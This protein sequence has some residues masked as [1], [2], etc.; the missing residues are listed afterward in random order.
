MEGRMPRDERPRR[1]RLGVLTVGVA[2]VLLLAVAVVPDDRR[3]APSQYLRFPVVADTYVSAAQPDAV[4]GAS[5]TLVTAP[6]GSKRAY[7]RFVITGVRGRVTA[8]TLRVFVT[9]KLTR[10]FHV[11]ATDGADL[12][13]GAT[14]D[15]SA[16]G[17]GAIVGSS[18]TV[19]GKG[20]SFVSVTPLVEGD[21]SVTLALLASE[22][23]TTFASRESGAES[24]LIVR[25]GRPP[26]AAA[27][28]ARPAGWSAR[29]PVIGAA[30]DIACD[31]TVEGTSEHSSSAG[32][33][34]QQMATSDLL[35]RD[36]VVAV[37]PLGDNQ[38][39]DGTLAKYRAWYAPSWGR[40]KRITRP[41]PGNHEYVRSG[42]SLDAS[43][44]FRYFGAAAGDPAKGY[45]S[46]DIGSWHLIALNSQCGALDGCRAGSRQERWL[47]RDLAEHPARCTLA[48]WHEPRFS[49]G[50]HGQEPVYDDFWRDLYAAGV[51]VVLNGHNHVYERFAPQDPDAQLDPVRGIREFV[52]GTG[53]KNHYSP[54]YAFGTVQ[55]NS[56]VRDAQTFGVLELTLHDGGYDWRF[57]PTAGGTF[58]DAGTGYCH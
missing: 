3:A 1:T 54:D 49:S 13:E 44:Y 42:D 37:L 11:A 7:L 58:T 18:G 12:D 23:V 19:T 21:G 24:Q 30:G 16:P 14:A 10:G 55:P 29:D 5:K 46:Y 52:V 17:V 43:G 57:V 45:Y 38:Y 32:A 8:A 25:T 33:R 6:G 15:A 34:C 50:P 26:P 36:R 41:V 22:D 27:A 40:L 2:L 48:Y 4:L 9:T 20:W 56:E 51:D 39:E 31:P 28:P 53:G 47:R 35:L